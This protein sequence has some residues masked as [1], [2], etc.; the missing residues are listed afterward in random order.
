MRP[1]TLQ[2]I[3]TGSLDGVTPAPQF[4]VPPRVGNTLGRDQVL[5]QEVENLGLVDLTGLL[6]NSGQLADRIIKWLLILGPNP[7]TNLRNVGIAFDGT[8]QQIELTIAA[9]PVT[10]VFSQECIRVPQ[11][12]QLYLDGMDANPGDPVIVRLG[13]WQP[14]TRL[15]LAAMIQAC[16]CTAAA[17]NEEGEPAFIQDLPLA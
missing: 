12:G 16:C 3:V 6:G 13:I 7:R 14:Q 4:A 2:Y 17:L 8:F 1:L 5:T 15:E 9:A 10:G 11:S